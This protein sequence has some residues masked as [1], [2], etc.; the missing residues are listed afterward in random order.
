MQCIYRVGQRS[1][2][3]FNYVNIMTYKLQKT[4]SNTV[5]TILVLAINYSQFKCAHLFE[6]IFI[7]ILWE[8]QCFSTRRLWIERYS[9]SVNPTIV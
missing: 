8:L 4:D 7:N 9:S 6:N 2:T 1:V 3:I 5:W